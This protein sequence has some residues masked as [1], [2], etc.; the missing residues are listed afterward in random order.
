MCP[1]DNK[2]IK[3]KLYTLKCDSI[4]WFKQCC[5]RAGIENYLEK[6]QKRGT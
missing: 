4:E 2:Y 6:C 5:G 1:T 3:K